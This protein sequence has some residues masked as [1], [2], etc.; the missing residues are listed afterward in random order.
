MPR[1]ADPPVEERAPEK[2][3]M[4]KGGWGTPAENVLKLY[5]RTPAPVQEVNKKFPI[6]KSVA[7]ESGWDRFKNSLGKGWSDFSSWMKKHMGWLGGI[8]NIITGFVPMGGLIK[9]A[10]SSVG[11]LADKAS[12]ANFSK[13]N[14]SMYDI[15]FMYRNAIVGLLFKLAIDYKVPVD[16]AEF[17]KLFHTTPEFKA[18][19]TG[20]Q[21]EEFTKAIFEAEKAAEKVITNGDDSKVP[22]TR[23]GMQQQ[24][25]ALIRQHENQKTEDGQ[26]M[27]VGKKDMYKWLT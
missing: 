8:V 18:Y 6:R 11:G 19:L 5:Q 23:K 21:S 17:K 1:P 14:L 15:L 9:S 2:V 22:Q 10:I 3:E 27:V 13:Q 24:T 26:P 16:T 7:A 4:K 12:G 25:T 20:S